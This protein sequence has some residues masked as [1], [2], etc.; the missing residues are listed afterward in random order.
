MGKT[1][2]CHRHSVRGSLWRKKKLIWGC[3]KFK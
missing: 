3:E 2:R 1:I